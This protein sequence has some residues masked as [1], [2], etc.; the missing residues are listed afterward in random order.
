MS[1]CDISNGSHVT[2]TGVTSLNNPRLMQLRLWL[3]PIVVV[4][5]LMSLLGTLYLAYVLDPQKNLHGFPVALVNQDVG[6]T[7]NGQFQNAGKQLADGI[8]AGVPNDK[9]DLR[10][11][12]IG[13]AQTEMSLG[14]TYGTIVIPG[15]FTKRLAILGAAGIVPGDVERPMVTVQTNPR[16]GTYATAIMQRIAD[17]ALAQ[18]NTKVGQ[19]LTD[20]V[21]GQIG[22][23]PLTGASRLTLAQPINVVTAPFHPLPDGTGQ[24]LSAFFYTLLLLLAGFTGAMSINTM[25]DATLGFTPSEY[26]PW[27][28]HF[29]ATPISRFRTLLAKWGIMFIVANVVSATYVIIGHALGM[30]IEKPLA[31]F[32]FG[33]FAILAVGVTALSV[34]AAVGTA[35]LLVNLILFIVLG[36]PSCGGTVPIEAVPRYISWLA[37]FE[38]MHQ[39]FLGVRSILYLNADLDAGLLRA[40]WMTLMGLVIG[41]AIGSAVTLFYDRKGL[42]RRN[43]LTP[44]A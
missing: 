42:H 14:Q 5:L 28:T 4:T 26:G 15:D 9:I 10:V 19:Q 18:A 29:P 31:L 2:V 40:C 43:M 38:P 17:E 36:L 6:D 35:G 27:Y 13:E 8:I 44:P 11:V 3:M 12:G 32:F 24:G 20:L 23:T 22:D 16:V 41:L 39:V 1:W 7:L 34:L 21:K 37:H 30:P 33:A 25:T